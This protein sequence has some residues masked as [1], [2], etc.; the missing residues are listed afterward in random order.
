MAAKRNFVVPVSPEFWLAGNRDVAADY[1]T[2]T[3]D[4]LAAAKHF[5]WYHHS[6]RVQ[7]R[8]LYRRSKRSRHLTVVPA[9]CREIAVSNWTS[10]LGRPAT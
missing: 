2:L 9:S 6:R 10:D 4:C 7:R 8:W 3:L 1:A 5:G